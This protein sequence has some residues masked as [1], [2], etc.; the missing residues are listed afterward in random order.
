MKRSTTK[1]LV[2]AAA[3][4]LVILLIWFVGQRNRLVQLDEQVEAAWSEIDNQL[5]RRS[6]L[7]PNLVET[8]RGFAQ[9]E[10][11]VF[12]Q[13]SDARARLAGA[14]SVTG[15]AEAS[16]ELEGALSRLLVVAEAYPDLRSNENFIRLQDELAGTE[17]RIAVARRRYNEAVQD[18][19]TRI[20][21]FPTSLAADAMGIDQREYFQIDDSSREVP[22]V[23]LGG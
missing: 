5:Q 3:A 18:L 11:E 13:I 7:I 2:P 19:N 4:L 1:W 8:V 17:N 21:L 14:E 12:S 15:T 6:D 16:Q 10:L 23:D 9:Q 20:R 22:Q